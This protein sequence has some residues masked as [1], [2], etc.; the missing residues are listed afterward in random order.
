MSLFQRW[1]VIKLEQL[2]YILG[3]VNETLRWK[4]L[5]Y[6]EWAAIIATALYT[7]GLSLQYIFDY[8]T[9]ISCVTNFT[10]VVIYTA[11][12]IFSYN[13]TKKL[14]SMEGSYELIGHAEHILK[15][16]FRTQSKTSTVTLKRDSKTQITN[17]M[18]R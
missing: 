7:F 5:Y 13:A 14:E 1:A 11:F 12:L 16:K 6:R 4:A 17:K 9:W 3:E 10:M 8:S 15:K 2:L 18:Q